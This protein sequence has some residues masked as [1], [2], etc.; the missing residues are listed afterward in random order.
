MFIKPK[1]KKVLF[2]PD[3]HAPFHDNQALR[4]L[5]S[6]I[7]WWNP[8]EIFILGD[9]IDFY[10][11]SNFEKN[12]DR[13]FKL[14]QDIN[15]GKAILY[16]IADLA[17]RAR[18]VFIPGNHEYRLERFLWT[19]ASELSGLDGLKLENLLEL[20]RIGYQYAP[21][22]RIN[23]KGTIIKHGDIVRKFAGYTAKGEFENTGLSGVSGH[24]HRLAVH[25][26]TN[27]A[28]HFQWMEAGCLCKLEQEY[29]RGKTPNWQQGFGIGFYKE[30]SRRYNIQA[31]RIINGKAMWGG[32]EFL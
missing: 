27:E 1:Y 20:K 6:F 23:Y 32:Y 31:V 4:C 10:P 26:I 25:S 13:I 15:E 16:K 2:V 24:T 3:I 8:D 14:Q 22:G 21:Q 11:L 9:T 5:Y 28:G 12:P 7:S 30:N 29:M 19:K 17:P 18:K